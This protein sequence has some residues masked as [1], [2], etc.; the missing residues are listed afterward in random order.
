MLCRNVRGGGN[1]W[2]YGR[3][4]GMGGMPGMPG[5]AGGPPGNPGFPGRGGGYGGYAREKSEGQ[6]IDQATSISRG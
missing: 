5:S 6:A 1:G 3:G 4:G 2:G